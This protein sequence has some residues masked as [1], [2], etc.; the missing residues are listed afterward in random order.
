MALRLYALRRLEKTCSN[1]VK[2]KADIF[3]QEK[4]ILYNPNPNFIKFKLYNTKA[5]NQRRTVYVESL[6]FTLKELETNQI[7]GAKDKNLQVALKTKV[8]TLTWIGIK[9]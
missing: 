3:F 4:C 2:R 1:K 6:D 8:G 5:Q 9:S 7:I